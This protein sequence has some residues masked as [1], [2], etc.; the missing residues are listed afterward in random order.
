MILESIIS[1]LKFLMS[2]ITSCQLE[3]NK[4]DAVR[5]GLQFNFLYY[6]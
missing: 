4:F 1:T 2:K 3:R 6:G 5:F